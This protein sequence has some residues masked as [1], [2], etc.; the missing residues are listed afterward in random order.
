MKVEIKKLIDD[1]GNI[2]LIRFG[3]S[4]KVS[5]SLSFVSFISSEKKM[6][7]YEIIFFINIYKFFIH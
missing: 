4:E 5:L 3:C 7:H 1:K 6:F 2:I